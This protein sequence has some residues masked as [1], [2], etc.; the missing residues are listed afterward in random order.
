VILGERADASDDELNDAVI[1]DEVPSIYKDQIKKIKDSIEMLVKDE[2]VAARRKQS[3]IT[4]NVLKNVCNHI[5]VNGPPKSNQNHHHGKRESDSLVDRRRN[6]LECFHRWIPLKFVS[7]SKENGYSDSV[8]EF[9][10]LLM[11]SCN[12]GSEFHGFSLPKDLFH[13]KDHKN[14]SFIDYTNYQFDLKRQEEY[15]YVTLRSIEDSKNEDDGDD[16]EP[17]LTSTGTV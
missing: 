6:N 2:V 11:Q 12:F 14:E 1:D 8:K 15:Y 13:P 9:R 10:D 5:E 4:Q 3:I 16:D 17:D 7:Y